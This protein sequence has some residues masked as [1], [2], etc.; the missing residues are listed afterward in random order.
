MIRTVVFLV[1]FYSFIPTGST[2]VPACY[3]SCNQVCRLDES[4]KELW[5][6][7]EGKCLQ[8]G[9]PE[10]HFY[11]KDMNLKKIAD[12]VKNK[13]T[14]ILENIEVENRK[15]L[16]GNKCAG[17]DLLSE[18]RTEFKT[19]PTGEKTC[20]SAVSNTY[21]YREV[22]PLN[23]EETCDKKNRSK[24]FKKFKNYIDP[25]LDPRIKSTSPN[26]DAFRGRCSDKEGD[27]P[28]KQAFVD[29][30][31]FYQ[32][33]PMNTCDTNITSVLKIDP[34]TC[35]GYLDLILNC[36]HPTTTTWMIVATLPNYDVDIFY[37]ARLQCLEEI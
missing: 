29:S 20:K 22:Q 21:R 24:V 23:R 14:P 33:C 35:R 9:E 16:K 26:W 17:C 37:N 7:I 1:F 30:A 12:V 18:I 27:C 32:K 13:I 34:V 5:E 36:T 11:G 6:K 25:F 3:K 2:Q 15:K 4:S 8:G 28:Y 19:R 10:K 31:D